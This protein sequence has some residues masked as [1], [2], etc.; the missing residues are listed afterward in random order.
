MALGAHRAGFHHAWAVDIDPDA[1]STYQRNIPDAGPGSVHCGDV[2]NIDLNA[3][4]PIDCLAFGFPCNDFSQVG[5]QKGLDGSYGPLYQHGVS[6]L[7]SHQP[8]AFV[9][10]NVGGLKSANGG[11]AMAQILRDLAEAGYRVSVEMYRAEDFGVPQ[12]RH[13]MVLVGIRHDLEIE[14]L[15]PLP[16]TPTPESQVTAGQALRDI[17]SWAEHQ[18]AT[19]QS[20]VVIE[21]LEHIRPGENAFNASLPEELK[22]NVQGARISQIYR[23]LD[24]DRPAY[25][26]TGSGGGGTHIY[27]WSEP[28]ALTN[29]ERARLQ[30]FPDR[31]VFSGGKES[32]RRQIGMAVPPLLAEAIFRQLRAILELSRP[33]PGRAVVVRAS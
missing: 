5:E 22:L 7:K 24:P 19:R 8:L 16:I 11:E 10:E 18:E 17:P 21:R 29:R 14:F 30:T 32:V 28:R 12:R 9:A 25:T 23:R 6:V 31:F 33:L 2:R 3:L 27:H 13:R 26:V 15:P 1:C 4:G 20:A